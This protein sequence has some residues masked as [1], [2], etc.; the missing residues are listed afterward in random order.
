MTMFELT[1]SLATAT[2]EAVVRYQG[3]NRSREPVFVAH[4]AV[5]ASFKLH[6]K[7]A[8]AALSADGLRL[9]LILG[10]SPLPTDC[11]VEFGAVALFVKVSPGEQVTGEVR[12]PI[13]VEEWNAYTLPGAE[14]ET[15]L[16]TV[17]EVTLTVEVIPQSAATRIEPA[18]LQRAYWSVDG[19][20]IRSTLALTPATPLP[21]R[22][23]CDNF[24]RS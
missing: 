6:P 15:E 8:Y 23:R 21:V 9:N 4:L 13:P 24:P 20:A 22:K 12:L 11:D 19:R 3:V 1:G 16:V 10:A 7:T 18:R 14:V 5:D 17:G 2:A